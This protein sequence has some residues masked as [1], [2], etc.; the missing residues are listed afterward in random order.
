MVTATCWLG[1]RCAWAN[2]RREFRGLEKRP[3][4]V[5]TLQ[6]V[7]LVVRACAR[8]ER[9]RR[10]R[11][12]ERES[13]EVGASPAGRTSVSHLRVCNQ[14]RVVVHDSKSLNS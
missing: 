10:Q 5:Q 8:R 14:F 1:K 11:E 2:L 6:A 3:K 9:Q 12:S 4:F 13:E 7:S